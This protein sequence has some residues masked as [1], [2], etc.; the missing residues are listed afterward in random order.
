M[1]DFLESAKTRLPQNILD[2]LTKL[3]GAYEISSDDVEAF[4]MNEN[5]RR[6]K[7]AA[8]GQ[9]KPPP[10]Q[11]N[12][13]NF[14]KFKE[15]VLKNCGAKMAPSTSANP[16]TPAAGAGYGA[17][18]R[19]PLGAAPVDSKKARM[20]TGLPSNKRLQA[21]RQSIGNVGPI[22]NVPLYKPGETSSAGAGQEKYDCGNALTSAT[23]KDNR[24]SQAYTRQSFSGRPIKCAI[25]STQIGENL[26]FCA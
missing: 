15:F 26:K 22:A 2:E 9:A 17:Q 7:S 12:A 14:V 6:R 16:P 20:S 11:L 24:K 18:K 3:E 21:I 23:A 10:A 4:Q 8:P 19:S 13:G 1:A 5:L 25:K